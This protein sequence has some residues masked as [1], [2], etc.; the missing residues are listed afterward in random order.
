MKI[1]VFV[2]VVC[3]VVVFKALSLSDFR[4][5]QT[6]GYTEQRDGDDEEEDVAHSSR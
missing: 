1:S 3:V 4:Q 2:C 6:A 5:N